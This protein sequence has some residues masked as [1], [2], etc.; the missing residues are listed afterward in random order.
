MIRNSDNVGA[1][2]LSD[3][4]IMAPVG[5]WESL[6]AALNS[7]ANSIYFGVQGL[8]MR[9]ASSVNFTLDDLANIIAQCKAKGV[10]T[11]LTLNTVLYDNEMEYMREVVDRAKSEGITAVIVSDQAA[12][13]EA[14][15]KGVEVH[16][17]TQLN[18]SNIES[19]Q[20]YAQ[21]ADVVVLARE[22]DLTQVRHIYDQII[23]RDIRGPKGELV[24]IEMFAHGALCM[25]VSGKCYLSLHEAWKSANRGACRQICRRSYDVKD[26]E[27]GAELVVDNK[28]IMSPQDLCTLEFLGEMIEAGVRVLKIEGRARGAEYV[29]TVVGGYR[30]ALKH[31]VEE[32]DYSAEKADEI[33]Q[34]LKR[35]FN[36]GFWGGYYLGHKVGAELGQWTKS[37]GSSATRKKVYVGKVTN[38]FA[39]ISVAEVKIEAAPL[40]VGDELLFVGATTGAAEFKLAALRSANGDPAESLDQGNICS[41]HCGEVTV[42]RGDKLYIMK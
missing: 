28:Y 40:A 7:G 5:S 26:I 42:R 4:E 30:E 17:S 37:Y 32:G 41:V 9:S 23:A 22:L 2:S 34:K 13:L 24:E 27:T 3:V 38:F 29:A 8:N 39:K 19:V 16:I 31:I 1:V 6:A 15:R 36:R 14:R 25:A 33:I 20:F 35:V 18:I 12:M 10:K 11:Y 21:W